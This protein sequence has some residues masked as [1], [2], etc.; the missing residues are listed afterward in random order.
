MIQRFCK[1]LDKYAVMKRATRIFDKFE[2]SWAIA[3]AVLAFLNRG[4]WKVSPQTNTY[5]WNKWPLKLSHAYL[6]TQ[7]CSQHETLLKLNQDACILVNESF[8]AF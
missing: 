7:E 2:N 5:S 8:L 6:N 3:L 4:F 1:Y